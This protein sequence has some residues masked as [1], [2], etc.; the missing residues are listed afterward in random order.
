MSIPVHS[1]GENRI[2]IKWRDIYIEKDEEEV[3]HRHDYYQ[4]MFLERV[5]GA[6]K[7]DFQNYQAKNRSVHFISMSRVHQVHFTPSTKGGLI[8][9]PNSVFSQ[10]EKTLLSTLLYFRNTANPV[11]NLAEKDFESIMELVIYLKKSLSGHV[12]ELSR[13]LLFSILIQ[14][15]ELYI[16]YEKKALPGSNFN[17]LI[18]YRKWLRS[19]KGQKSPDIFCRDSKIS[20]NRLNDLCK[21]QFG[22]TALQI[23]HEQR[24]LEAKRLLVYTEKQIKE[25]AYDCGFEDVSYFNR[26]FK[27]RTSLTPSEFRKRH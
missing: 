22:K 12:L 1:D 27:K 23:L 24:L 6:H 7:I 19:V 11:L 21:K 16:R 3:A 18:I 2:F 9:F 10:S 13:H 4:V 8:L 14:L 26:F 20:K 25:I 15:R 5:S 17:E